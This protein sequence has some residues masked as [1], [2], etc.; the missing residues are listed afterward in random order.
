MHCE[1]NVFIMRLT[2]LKGTGSF[3]GIVSKVDGIKG[4]SEPDCQFLG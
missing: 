1:L 2:S 3:T 4:C